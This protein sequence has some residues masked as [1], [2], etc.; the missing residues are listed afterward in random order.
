MNITDEAK[1]LRTELINMIEELQKKLNDEEMEDM[2]NKIN[3]IV[4]N[5]E[6]KQQ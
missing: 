2:Y 5:G 1:E 3:E 6:L 4:E